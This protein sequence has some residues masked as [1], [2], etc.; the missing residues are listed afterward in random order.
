MFKRWLMSW[1]TLVCR[2]AA[3]LL[4][5]AW[6]ERSADRAHLLFEWAEFFGL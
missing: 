6:R 2:V 3:E 1:R 4:R 5:R